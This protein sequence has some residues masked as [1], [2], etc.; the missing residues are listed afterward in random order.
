MKF[1]GVEEVAKLLKISHSGVLYQIKTGKLKATRVGKIY[2]ITQ[3]D[4][5]D[6]LKH[7]REVKKKVKKSSQTKLKFD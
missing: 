3:E 7:H 2:I 5:G 1:F 6:F 4:F